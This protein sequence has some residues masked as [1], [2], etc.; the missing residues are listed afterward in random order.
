M[1]ISRAGYSSIM[2]LA[3][4]QKPA[5]LVAT[6]GQTEQEYL[7]ERLSKKG[8]CVMQQQNALNIEEGIASLK[9]LQRKRLPFEGDVFKERLKKFLES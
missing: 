5:I 9:Q 4:L 1:V 6:P 2:E 8:F 7:A 3:S